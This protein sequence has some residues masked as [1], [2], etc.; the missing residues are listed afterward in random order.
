MLSSFIKIIY[1]FCVDNNNSINNPSAK[2]R[3]RNKLLP[4]ILF[5]TLLGAGSAFCGTD[6]ASC[7]TKR[8][9]GDSMH[10]KWFAQLNLTDDQKAKLK[11]M[12]KEMGEFRKVN[13][14]KMKALREKSKVEFLKAAPSKTVLYGF[15][16]EMG[17]LHK[18]MAEKM[19][20]H[21]L[22]MKTILT[23]EQFEK[24]LNFDFGEGNGPMM[25]RGEGPHG[26]HPHNDG[27][28]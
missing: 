24:M 26:D 6:S 21:I 19:A 10:Q 25:H 11:D 4:A 22:K 15:A 23:K 1:A 2:R 12:R 3:V 27:D 17:D 13:F 18:A 9:P 5:I 8:A 14:E 7:T 16:K 28:K 20:D